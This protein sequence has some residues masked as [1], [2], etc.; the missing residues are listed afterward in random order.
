MHDNFIVR[1]VNWIEAKHSLAEVREK[2]F[3]CEQR[4]DPEIEI[5]GKDPECFHVLVTTIDGEAIGAGRLS[6]TGKIG[7]VSVLMPY[8]GYGLG[9]RILEALVAIAKRENLHPIKL[10]A[11]VHAVE[12][13][14]R[15]QFMPHGPVFM[16]AGIP[17][18]TMHLKS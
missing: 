11:Q 17:H 6:R 18:Q 14:Q 4:V 9:S 1:E 2:V 13:Y 8:R 7:R 3:I 15:H 12:F 16:E 5:D 10:N